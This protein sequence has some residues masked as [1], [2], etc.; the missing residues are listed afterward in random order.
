LIKLLE[1]PVVKSSKSYVDRLKSYFITGLIAVLPLLL[2]IFVLKWISGFVNGYIGPRTAFGSLLQKIGYK[3]SPISNLSLAYVIG[4]L[5]FVAGIFLLGLLLESRARSTMQHIA[6]RTIFQLPLIRT[7]YRTTDKF[8]SLMPSSDTDS[9]SGMQVVFCR[10]GV[11]SNSA[12]FLCLLASPEVYKLGDMSYVIVMIPTAPIPVGGAMLF[13]PAE[14][15]HSTD[16]NIDAFAG[17][18]LS[19]GVTTAQ[20]ALGKAISELAIASEGVKPTPVISTL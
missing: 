8:I 11:G 1:F 7:I 12:G 18:Y 19:M 20:F 16:M 6:Q 5:L 15:V 10:F 3:F 9:V 14:S 2:T 13:V 17:S 4:V